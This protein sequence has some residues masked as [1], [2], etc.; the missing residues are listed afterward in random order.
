MAG[1]MAERLQEVRRLGRTHLQVRPVASGSLAITRLYDGLRPVRSA[2]LHKRGQ[3]RSMRQ[4]GA[5]HNPRSMRGRRGA[6][7]RVRLEL[8][9]RRATMVSR[10]ATNSTERTYPSVR[11][12]SSACRGPFTVKE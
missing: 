11:S 6:V 2:G 8:Q 5:E 4:A 10:I 1:Q 7:Q 9:R 12:Q 3:L